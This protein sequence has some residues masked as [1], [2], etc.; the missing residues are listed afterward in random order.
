MLEALRSGRPINKVLL[1]SNIE[2]HG[3]IGEILYLARE[4]GIPVEYVARPALDRLT[5]TAAHQ[6]VI[7]FASMKE[8]VD[9][10]D[11]LRISGGKNEPPLYIILDS[12]EDPQN[13]GSIVR[14]AEATGVHGV[15]IWERRAVGLTAVV[16][17]ATAG[18]PGICPRRQGE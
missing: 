10:D 4:Q 12:V 2:R 16:A 6:G 11:L 3:V 7:A 9:L 14:T 13:L 17:K 8:Y 1:A 18:A 5:T 15:I